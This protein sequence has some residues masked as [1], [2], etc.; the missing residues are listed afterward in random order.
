[1]VTAPT[2]WANFTVEY[3]QLIRELDNSCHRKNWELAIE[4]CAKLDDVTQSV[5]R[6]AIQRMVTE[7]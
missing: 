3:P 1:M 7:K 2:D 6:H 4:L 5:R